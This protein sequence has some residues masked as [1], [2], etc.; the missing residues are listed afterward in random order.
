MSRW[1]PGWPEPLFEKPPVR[2][3]RNG[4]C[5]VDPR[6]ILLSGHGQEEI[7]KML[8]AKWVTS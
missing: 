2:I 5:H 4:V 8:N 3:D 1:I 6:D 7:A